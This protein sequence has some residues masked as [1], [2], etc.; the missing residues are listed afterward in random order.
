[1]IPGSVT[2]P[3]IQC[4]QARGLALSGGRLKPRSRSVDADC[5]TAKVQAAIKSKAPVNLTESVCAVFIFTA[6]LK[7]KR[8]ASLEPILL[9]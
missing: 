9:Q 8:E 1:V 5:D 3:L 7:W 6:A 2:L 4:H